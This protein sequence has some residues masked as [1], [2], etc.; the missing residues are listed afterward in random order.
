MDDAVYIVAAGLLEATAASCGWQN[1]RELARFEGAVLDR[2][3]F[4]HPFLDRDSLGIIED[5]V[6]LE[7][8]T[9]AVHTAPGHGQEDY[10]AGMQYG[11]PIYCPIDARGR[12]FHATGASGTLPEVL[13][14]K[15]VWEANPIVSGILREH[16]ALLAEK[17]FEHSYPHCW[18]CHHPTIFRA[19]EMCIRDSR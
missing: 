6:T 12:F 7:Q 13:I 14:G 15:T 18:R 8:G 10:V 17:H 16:G 11:L 5:Y 3:V 1:V 2:A 4:R 19:T 9:G